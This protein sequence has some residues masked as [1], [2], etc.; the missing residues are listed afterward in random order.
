MENAAHAFWLL[1][2]YV[3]GHVVQETSLPIST[4]EEV[5][6]SAESPLER[7]KM[8]GFP[9][10]TEIAQHALTSGTASTTSSSSASI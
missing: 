9:H 7:I 5:R 6:D 1:D 4:S 2:S 8:D 10:L 3:Y